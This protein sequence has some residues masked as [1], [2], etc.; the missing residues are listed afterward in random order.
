MH[1][2]TAVITAATA[3][4][5]SAVTCTKDS[6]YWLHIKPRERSLGEKLKL[7]SCCIDWA[8]NQ[9]WGLR[10]SCK[11]WVFEVNELFIIWLFLAKIIHAEVITSLKSFL[12]IKSF[13][14]L[15]LHHVCIKRWSK[16]CGFSLREVSIIVLR[17]SME[18][19]RES[20]TYHKLWHGGKDHGETKWSNLVIT[21]LHRSQIKDTTLT[22]PSTTLT[23]ATILTDVATWH[24]RKPLQLLLLLQ[25]LHLLHVNTTATTLTKLTTDTTLTTA[26][27][28]SIKPGT[29]HSGTC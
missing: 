16:R 5:Q 12:S 18:K 25:L 13:L 11:D 14:W 20:C 4:H 24:L 22:T 19:S 8:I 21:K 23:T 15:R 27:R 26:T 2:R 7:R 10:F 9:D 6:R 28:A 17:N 1:I 3:Y 29:R